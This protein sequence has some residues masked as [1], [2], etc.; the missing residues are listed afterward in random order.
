[1]IKICLV[2]PFCPLLPLFKLITGQLF[3]GT[4]CV[5]RFLILIHDE[6]RLLILVKLLLAR[7]FVP[8]K[9]AHIHNILRNNL[10]QDG[11]FKLIEKVGQVLKGGKKNKARGIHTLRHLKFDTDS[12]CFSIITAKEGRWEQ[13]KG[14][15]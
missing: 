3:Q 1:M 15:S 12:I 9:K 10:C 7:E 2:P 13:V 6:R 4:Q 8:W 11:D 5:G 14:T